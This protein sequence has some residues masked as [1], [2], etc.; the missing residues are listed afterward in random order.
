MSVLDEQGGA[1]AITV[2]NGEGCGFVIPGTGMHM[3]NFLGEDDINPAGFHTLPVGSPIP[4]MM[5]VTLVSVGQ[6]DRPFAS[7][8][9]KYSTMY[10]PINAVKN[11]I[12]VPRNSHIPSFE[13]GIG[14]PIFTAGF[15]GV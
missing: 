13:F 1:A 2:S 7:T 11:M 3:N 5:W 8:E 14:S 10:V 12:S 9:P 15:A 6:A 4:T